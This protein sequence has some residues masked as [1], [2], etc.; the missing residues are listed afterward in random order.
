MIFLLRL[1][2][3]MVP[4]F[5]EPQSHSP[6]SRQRIK[7]SHSHREAEDFQGSRNKSIQAEVPQI[8]HRRH[9]GGVRGPKWLC[10]LKNL[11]IPFK[12]VKVSLVPRRDALVGREV[13]DF[14]AIHRVKPPSPLLLV[15]LCRQPWPVRQG[16]VSIDPFRG[17]DHGVSILAYLR[18]CHRDLWVKA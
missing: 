7:A 1:S 15:S 2:G 6:A 14:R 5:F 10:H 8:D 4:P 18:T 13:Q 3:E 9:G 12:S 16:T 11:P 17:G